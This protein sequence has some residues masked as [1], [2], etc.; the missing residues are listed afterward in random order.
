[1]FPL[2]LGSS[3]PDFPEGLLEASAIHYLQA[4]VRTIDFSYNVKWEGDCT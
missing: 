2:V 1:M 3:T 4:E